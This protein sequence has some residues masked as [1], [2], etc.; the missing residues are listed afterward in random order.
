MSSTRK[1]TT[2]ASSTGP[3]VRPIGNRVLATWAYSSPSEGVRDGVSGGDNIY[4]LRPLN[5]AVY[6][7]IADFA[8][9]SLH[10]KKLGLALVQRR[11]VE[12]VRLRDLARLRGEPAT[13]GDEL[14]Q[15]CLS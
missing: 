11:R 5:E 12:H 1:Y 2:G 13:R 10:L 9:A 14:D 15:S 8:C 3:G 4:M 7:R 6:A